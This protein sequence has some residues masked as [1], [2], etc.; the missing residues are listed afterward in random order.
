[1]QD[2]LLKKNLPH[3]AAIA[4]FI[5]LTF[6]YFSPMLKGK[7]IIQSDMVSNQGMAKEI[8]DFREKYNED[9]L[10]TNSMFGGMPAY[11]I[12]IKPEMGSLIPYFKTILTLGFKGPAMLLFSYLV[13]FYFLLLVLRVNPWLCIIGSLAFSFTSYTLIIIEAG[14]ITK[15]L[16]ISYMAPTLAAVLLILRQKYL[17]GTALLALFASLELYSSHVQI[18]YYLLIIIGVITTF[19]YVD[20][21]KQKQHSVILKTLFSFVIAAII[22]FGCNSYNLLNT[23]DYVNHTIRGKSEL[24]ENKENKTSGLDRDYVV[25]WSMGK[26][27]T[28]SLLIPG[29]KGRSSGFLI[30]ETPSALKTVEPQMRETIGNNLPQY[31]GD[32]PFTSARYAGAIVVFLFVLGLFLVEGK[33]KWSILIV[34]LLSMLLAWGKNFMG[35]TNLF[36]D[37]VPAYNKFRA[38]SMILVIAEFTIPLLAILGVSKI[39]QS[40]T[41]LN[42]KIKIPLINSDLTVKNAFF[43]SFVLT[44]GISILYYLIPDLTSFSSPSDEAIFSQIA[45]SN[46]EEIAHRFMFNIEEARRALFKQDALRSFGFIAVA[47]VALW[48]YLNKKLNTQLLLIILGL[49]ILT[50]LWMVDKQFLNDKNFVSKQES[51]I[52]FP[53]TLA[54]KEILKDNDVNYRVLN[55]AVN[56]FNDASTSYRHKS[57][58][59]YHAAKLRRYQDLIEKHLAREMASIVN[60]LQDNPTDSSIKS[61]LLSNGVLNMLNTKYIIYNPNTSPLFNMYAN[62]NAWFVK[63]IK[64]VKNADEEI[65]SLNTINTKETGIVDEKFKQ[66]ISNLNF[67]I[68]STDNIKLTDYKPNHLTYESN[69]SQSMPVVF[70]EIYY[71]DG[72]NA[73][74]DNVQSAYF[75]TNYV[76]RGMVIPAGKHKI[77]FKFEPPQNQ[78]RLKTSFAF[79]ILLILLLGFSIYKELKKS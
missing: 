44:G 23:M 33:L 7:V 72:W 25:Q 8:N 57:V 4:I 14:H 29:F 37:Y 69:T 45:Q 75:R 70:S 34:T 59:G 78:I 56:T 32:Q 60:T 52:P 63:N 79:S 19:E 35:L 41:E 16:A 10:W 9:P 76:L 61:V 38:V 58:G 6:T 31:W 51:K 55:L 68:D 64:F 39:I 26:A 73:Y 46:G 40:G 27:E 53:E 71:E 1:M 66:Q 77:E 42:N 28:M 5:A 13:G 36:L 49:G 15:A 18:T 43:I 21:I 62:G 2:N 11:L 12:S 17:L 22:A 24:S 65:T 30:N 47:A 50:D 3:I 20:L 54:D 74:I 67:N 48:F